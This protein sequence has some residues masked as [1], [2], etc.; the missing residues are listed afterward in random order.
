MIGS[1][2]LS[3]ALL[4]SHDLPETSKVNADVEFVVS[5]GDAITKNVT[6]TVIGDE[7]FFEGDIFVGYIS[8]DGTLLVNEPSTARGITTQSIIVSNPSLKWSQGI[9]PY[10]INPLFNSLPETRNAILNAMNQIASKSGV[11]FVER[12]GHNNYIEFSPSANGLCYSP[13]GMR[14]GKQ[15][16]GLA[17]YCQSN[18]LN[19]IS[20]IVH[21][22][23]HSLGF[24]HTHTRSDRDD[25]VT[26]HLDNIRP[27]HRHNFNKF[28]LGDDSVENYGVYDI[29]SIMH[30][31]RYTNSANFV[32]DINK[33]M[34]T[35]KNSPNSVTGG[36]FMTSNDVG[37][38]KKLYGVMPPPN[39]SGL[40]DYCHGRARLTWT[41]IEN[42]IEYKVGY[43][44]YG[45]W[46]SLLTTSSLFGNVNVPESMSVSVLACNANNECS[47]PSN[48]FFVRYY[49][50]CL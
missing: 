8:E 5:D 16:I 18:N 25:Y 17:G 35:V 22:I 19:S 13:I 33:P 46:Y 29:Y 37:S 21:E 34:L 36:S 38:L 2:F 48:Q 49:P 12:N 14:G 31:S 50:I 45:S 39:L 9:V 43:Y 42:A 15:T 6:L 27:E 10:V 40:S 11:R 26:I 47:L 20:V 3:L 4:V 23:L 7:A 1:V 30:Y 28:D 44:S 24:Y 41:Q 32:Y